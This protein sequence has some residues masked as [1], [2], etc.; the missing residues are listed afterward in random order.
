MTKVI[1]TATMLLQVLTNSVMD[2]TTTFTVEV[3]LSS[4]RMISEA[5]LA[6]PLPAIPMENPTS[7]VLRAGSL[8]VPSLVTRW[9][10]RGCGGFQQEYFYP[11]GGTGPVSRFTPIFAISRRSHSSHTHSFFDMFY[12]PFFLYSF[13]SSHHEDKTKPSI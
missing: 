10:H 6:T 2:T 12:F 1:V 4:M 11:P 13:H 9:S 3:K 7:A 5:S 8:F